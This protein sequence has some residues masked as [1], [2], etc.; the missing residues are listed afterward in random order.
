MPFSEVVDELASRAQQRLALAMTALLLATAALVVPRAAWPLPPLPQVSATYG[1]ATAMIQLA[2]F[3]L[4]MSAPR[5]PRSHVVIAAAYLYGGLMALLHLLTFPGAVVPGVP[6]FG[7]PNAVS[8]LFIA[9]RAGFAL[10]ILW[11]VLVA[12]ADAAPGAPQ[13]DAVPMLA[14]VLGALAACVAAQFSDAAALQRINGREVFSVF[15]VAGS[16]AAG[17]VAVTAIGLIW[18]RGLFRRS[19]YVWLVFVLAAEAV[20]VWLSTFSG[21]RYTLA[22][23]T[24]RIEGLAASAVVLLMLARH[25]RRL[26]AYLAETVAVLKARTDALQAEVHRRER[27]EVKLEQARKLEAVGQLGAGLAHDLNN[28]LQVITG[29]LAVLQRRAGAVADADAAVILRNIRKG[30]ALTRQLT[31]LSG[32]RSMSARPLDVGRTLADIAEGV[33]PLLDARH[34]LVLRADD[35]LPHATLD[36]VELEIA[37]TNLVT[38]ARDAMPEGG[39]IELIAERRADAAD[40]LGLRI[41][42]KDRG[43]GIAPAVLSRVFEPFFTTKEPGKGTGLGLAQVYGFVVASGGTVDVDSA[44]GQGTT[45]TMTFPAQPEAAAAAA[46]EALEPRP[47]PRAGQVVLLVDDND[48]VREASVELLSAGGFVVRAAASARE[49]LRL[50]GEG[51]R[52]DVLVSDIVMPGGMHGVDLVRHAKRAHPSLKAVLVTGYSDAAQ[53][54]R[55]EGLTVVGKPYDLASLLRALS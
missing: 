10:F 4:L 5:K 49:A 8:W 44:P 37:V 1:A 28:I 20:G 3:W 33:R 13:P 41:Q 27:V 21:G 45:V 35:D 30:E 55:E 23:Y 24:T 46:V 9:W 52:P 32:R 7:S 31:L 19:I 18:Q 11:A 26:Q 12:K 39:P 47:L 38:N 53:S 40:G 34:E 50:L 15:S 51:F 42:L 29:R 16:Y 22:W 6:V 2:T 43:V 25:F 54:A 48:D 36:G 14:A 17:V